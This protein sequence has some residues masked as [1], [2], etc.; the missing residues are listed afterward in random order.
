MAEL[1]SGLPTTGTNDG[2]TEVSAPQCRLS[3]V[4]SDRNQHPHSS[5]SADSTWSLPHC[6]HLHLLAPLELE[7]ARV[8]RGVPAPAAAA[9]LQRAR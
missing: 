8:L 6:T 7:R 2:V 5:N 3:K 4:H 9:R 1:H